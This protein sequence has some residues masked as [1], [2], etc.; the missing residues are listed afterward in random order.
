MPM[1]IGENRAKKM[2]KPTNWCCAW[3]SHCASPATTSCSLTLP[4]GGQPAA[5]ASLA[6]GDY[7]AEPT[8][9]IPAF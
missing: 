9:S 7:P 4:A 1:Q 2:L 3:G 8:V 5:P 6:D